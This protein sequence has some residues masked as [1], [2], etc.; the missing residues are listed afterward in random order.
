MP[1]KTLIAVAILIIAL[2]GVGVW[3]IF[4]R[5][6]APGEGGE[7]TSPGNLFGNL[8]PFGGDSGDRVTSDPT[9]GSVSDNGTIDIQLRQLTTEA[10]AGAVATSSDVVKVRY[11]E[12]ATG[13]IYEMN[14]QN[15]KR[16]RLTNTTVI[17][18][19]ETVWHKDGSQL[20][21][22][23]LNENDIIKTFAGTITNSSDEN[24]NIGQLDGVFLGDNILYITSSPDET[25]I[26]MLTRNNTGLSFTTAEFN[27]GNQEPVFSSPFSEW[28]PQWFEANTVSV[29]TKASALASGFLYF[30]DLQTGIFDKVLGDIDGL[31]TLVNTTGDMVL[32]SESGENLFTLSTLTIDEKIRSQL[33]VNTL[34]EKCV[35]S[36]IR[37]SVAYCGVPITITPGDYPDAWYQGLISFSDSIWEIDVEKNIVTFLV[38]PQEI[39]REE[40]DLINPLLSEDEKYLI[41]TNKKD[42]TLWRLSL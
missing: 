36:T 22:R 7:D 20:L 11:L 17:G 12:R 19:H 1:K 5:E 15:F 2:I 35:W 41:F 16:K 8:F 39:A 29:T 31:T 38:S 21:L 30:V 34:P 26:L 9:E 18:V 32:Y 4:S 27:G 33:S 25:S 10:V 23:Y 40:I 28:I 14:L 24:E 3:V 13:N 42:S 6:G 37:P